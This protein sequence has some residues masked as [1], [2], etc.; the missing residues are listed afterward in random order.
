VTVGVSVKLIEKVEVSSGVTDWVSL[1][2][3]VGVGRGDSVLVGVSVHVLAIEATLVEEVV[4]VAVEVCVSVG[5]SF[6][7]SVSV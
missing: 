1:L 4:V 2:E 6:R 5:V 3:R 7:L